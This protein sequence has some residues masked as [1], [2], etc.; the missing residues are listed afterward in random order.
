MPL[1]PHMCTHHSYCSLSPPGA[2]KIA[3]VV[4][5]CT[6]RTK[7]GELNR[8]AE[9]ELKVLPPQ[10]AFSL[11]QAGQGLPHQGE[12]PLAGCFENHSFLQVSKGSM[13]FNLAFPPWEQPGFQ[14]C[15]PGGGC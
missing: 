13:L 4:V 10:T 12:R 6:E 14:R 8:S 3:R 9:L 11:S 2:P 1:T 7:P 5:P 15:F